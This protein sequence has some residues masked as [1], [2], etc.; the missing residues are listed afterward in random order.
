MDFKS[1]NFYPLALLLQ[2]T[3]ILINFPIFTIQVT[4][5]NFSLKQYFT[6]I[7]TPYCLYNEICNFIKK[8]I[9]G[10]HLINNS[11]RDYCHKRNEIMLISL[12]GSVRRVALLMSNRNSFSST[13]QRLQFKLK[14]GIIDIYAGEYIKSLS[15]S[16]FHFNL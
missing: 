11:M 7:G 6:Q 10:H 13:F 8:T 5:S 3:K 2:L 1:L 16:I 15:T 12:K 9:S 4:Y 14:Y